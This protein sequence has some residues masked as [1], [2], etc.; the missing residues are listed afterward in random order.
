MMIK[1]MIQLSRNGHVHVQSLLL[2]TDWT[3]MAFLEL[4]AL[5][6]QAL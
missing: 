1:D 6:Q 2:K 5:R 4:C 3:V